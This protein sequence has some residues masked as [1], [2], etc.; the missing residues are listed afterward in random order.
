MQPELISSSARRLTSIFGP[1]P[2]LAVVLGSGFNG[3]A[4]IIKEAQAIPFGEL[5]GFPQPRVP[6]HAGEVIVGE[7][8]GLPILLLRGRAHFYEGYSMAE[9]T[10]PIRA[11]AAAG[12]RDLVLTNAAGAINPA[13]KTG[14]FMS[15]SDH[16]NFMGENPARGLPVGDGRCFVDLSEVYSPRLRQ[17]FARAAFDAGIALREGVYLAVSGPT[18]ET[19]AEINAFR[20]WGADAVG[21]STVPEAVIARYCGMNV[22]GL[23][24]ITNAAAGAG[25]SKISHEDVLKQGESSAARAEA[26]FSSF[27]RVCVKEA[28]STPPEPERI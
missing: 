15:I 24:C 4:R 18:Y 19:P 6:G 11:L 1:L 20:R 8:N 28:A 25:P 10:F 13:Y 22:A 16:M 7:L 9:I 3:L 26:L 17:Y 23:S 12:V 14:D 2:R 27:S 5:P 21:M